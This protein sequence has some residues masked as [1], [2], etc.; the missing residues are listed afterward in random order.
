MEDP[1]VD[2]KILLKWSFKS[3]MGGIEWIDL[4]QSRDRWRAVVDL[5][6]NL[7]VP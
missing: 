4:A 6:M 3:G 7:R 1:G 5:V 2:M